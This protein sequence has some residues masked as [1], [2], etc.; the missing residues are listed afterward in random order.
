MIRDEGK[1]TISDH[2]TASYAGPDRTKGVY[3]QMSDEPQISPRWNLKRGTKTLAPLALTAQ[4]QSTASHPWQSA[5]PSAK[6]NHI[7]IG[8]NSE[9]GHKSRHIDVL[10]TDFATQIIPES[11]FNEL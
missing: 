7:A 9:L 2:P 3:L 5:A 4:A 8:S 10:T 6:Q 11:K 1:V